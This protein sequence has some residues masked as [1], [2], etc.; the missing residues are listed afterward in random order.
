MAPVLFLKGLDPEML[1]TAI[2]GA[3]LDPCILSARTSLSSVARLQCPHVSLD[4]ATLGPAFHVGGSMSVQ[5]F[6]L[7]FV[8][9]CPTKGHSFNFAIEHQDGYIGFFPPG[10]VV[11]TLTPEGYESATLTVPIATFHTAIARHFPEIPPS[12]LERGAGIRVSPPVQDRLRRQIAAV[13][14]TL[15][16]HPDSLTSPVALHLIENELLATF[17]AAVRDGCSQLVPEPSHRTGGRLRRIRQARDFIAAHLHRPIYLDDL[18][19]ELGLAHR[20][21]ENLFR[22]LLGLNP[23]TYLR[24]RRLH[25]ARQALRQSTPSPG[26]VKNVALAWGYWH[27]G[28]FAHEYR[29][30]FGESPSETLA[31]CD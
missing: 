25:G 2:R 23:I 22:D 18:C 3:H 7:V 11:D 17:I 30:L 5:C 26:M 16:H 27:L 4:F 9:T 10:S 14:D 29:A 12:I 6:T 13:R 15:A 24:H 1:L 8:L 31:R 28:R 20:S 19:A 21:V